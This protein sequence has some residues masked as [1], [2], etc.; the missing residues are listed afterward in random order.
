MLLPELN[1]CRSAAYLLKLDASHELML[2]HTKAAMTDI[3]AMFA[4]SRAAGQLPIVISGLVAIGIDTLAVNALESALPQVR[5]ADEVAPLRTHEWEDPSRSMQRD[6]RGEEAFGLSAFADLGGGRLSLTTVRDFSQ[7]GRSVGVIDRLGDLP[8]C[9]FLLD[10]DQRGYERLMEEYQ[11]MM[12]EP[13]L[14]AAVRESSDEFMQIP[15]EGIMT[16]IVFP[17]FNRICANSAKGNAEHNAALVGI[18]ITRFRLD[19][20]TLPD[21]LDALLPQY[22]PQI[23]I[24]PFDGQPLRFRKTADDW[25]VYSIGPDNHDDGGTP[26]D[27]KTHTGNIS[28]V[29]KNH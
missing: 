1:Y 19:H 11:E 27:S 24:D 29:V 6:M 4:I 13:Y 17:S 22:L 23:P 20:L 12:A 10:G 25:R 28:F 2:G 15:R 8:F 16:G 5:N 21:T 3:D 26:Y 9:L 7:V 14:Q 18:A